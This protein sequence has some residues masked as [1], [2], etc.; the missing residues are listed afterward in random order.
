MS[1]TECAEPLSGFDFPS[2]CEA[3]SKKMR[4]GPLPSR[5]DLPQEDFRHR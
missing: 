5:N 2:R 1:G 4:L 3:Q